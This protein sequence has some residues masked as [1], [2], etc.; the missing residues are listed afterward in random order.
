[1]TLAG[2]A[3]A[4]YEA[5]AERQMAEYRALIA[6]LTPICER[7]YFGVF[8]VRGR[9]PEPWKGQVQK[10]AQEIAR[11]VLP[12]ATH[13]YLYHTVSGL[14]LLRYW[15]LCETHDAPKEQRLVVKKMVDA[16]LAHDPL[17]RTI[18]EEPLPLEET[19]EFV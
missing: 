4:V 13:A 5:C 1:P 17:F 12:V 8:P 15:R 18:L 19:P 7:A 9:N 2:E 6:L 10:K 11:Y 14:T 16:L 3:L